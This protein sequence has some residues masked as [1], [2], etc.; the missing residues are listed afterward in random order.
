MRI[1]HSLLL[2]FAVGV[3]SGC[4]GLGTLIDAIGGTLTGGGDNGDYMIRDVELIGPGG[5]GV[6]TGGPGV[7][8]V[9]WR[10]VYSRGP[11]TVGQPV[12][13]VRPAVA[14]I[15]DDNAFRDGDDVI[16]GMQHTS[17]VILQGPLPS[18]NNDQTTF[19]VNCVNGEVRGSLDSSG[20]GAAEI[21]ARVER[22]D[23]SGGIDSIQTLR[24]ECP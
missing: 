4:G 20:E 3:T 14:L 15:D 13:D 1:L 23:G 22:A 24:V 5:A 18:S 8:T 9:R 7:Y 17:S 21:Y 16:D 12:T 10:F 19:T 11:S 2:L 6:L